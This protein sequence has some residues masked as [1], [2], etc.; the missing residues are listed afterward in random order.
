MTHFPTLR[1][2]LL[3]YC[4][5]V[6]S[7]IPAVTAPLQDSRLRTLA[8]SLTLLV[9]LASG[10]ALWFLTPRMAPIQPG[11]AVKFWQAAGVR[12]EVK[13]DDDWGGNNAYF[14][15]DE[16]AAYE[17]GHWH[18][19]ELYSVPLKEVMPYFDKVVELLREDHE[20]GKDTVAVRGYIKWCEIHFQQRNAQALVASNNNEWQEKLAAQGSGV[21][22]VHLMDEEL[23]WKRWR[24]SHWYWACVA[25]EWTLFTGLAWFAAW[26]ILHRRSP[27]RL[28]FQAAV[29]PT[30][31]LL[32]TYLGYAT[33]AFTSAGPRGGVLYPFL[34]GFTR[35]GSMGK[36]DQWLLNRLPQILEPLSPSIGQ[37]MALTGLGMPG[38]TSTLIAGVVLGLAILGMSAWIRGAN[39]RSD[40]LNRPSTFAGLAT[41]DQ[42]P[43]SENPKVCCSAEDN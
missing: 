25:F 22:A 14:I 41:A 26:P 10:V 32:P 35:G 2:F 6:N 33:A 12:L 17:I 40:P 27:L 43:T 24:Q 15:D 34:L 38:P 37:P 29:V 31:F 1:K 5:F 9:A 21:L 11:S 23:F 19:S 16:W 18:G 7:R 3:S 20:Q 8:Q 28:A 39:F 30:L 4:E 36:F 42:C 13:N